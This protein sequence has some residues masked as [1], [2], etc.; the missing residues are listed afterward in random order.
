[1]ISDFVAGSDAPFTGY[2]IH[3]FK[4]DGTQLNILGVQNINSNRTIDVDF[5][6][7]DYVKIRVWLISNN[8][9][10]GIT[11]SFT[12]SELIVCEKD[13]YD[14]YEP[15]G[16]SP[17]P[18]YPS[19][20]KSV[21]YENLLN[22]IDG[23]NSSNGVV[24][25]VEKGI[26][27]MNGTYT[28]SDNMWFT[29]PSEEYSLKKGETYTYSLDNSEI[30]NNEIR[31][32]TLLS[33]YLDCNFSTINRTNTVTLIEDESSSRLQIRLIPGITFNNFIFKPKIEKGSIAH[34]YI[35]YGK[36]GIE[37]VNVGKNRLPN[38]PDKTSTNG[39]AVIKNKDG[40]ITLNGTSTA[41]SWVTIAEDLKLNANTYTL[42]LKNKM[43]GLGLYL[44]SD[45]ATIYA[46]TQ[47]QTNDYKTFTLSENTTFDVAR[48]RIISGTVFN[49]LT[50]YPMLEIGAMVTEY[51][52]CIS[53]STVFVLNEP[54]RS[55]PNG[56][57]DIAYLQNGKL[58]VERK[59]GR[60]IFDGSESGWGVHQ[61]STDTNFLY[62]IYQPNVNTKMPNCV[63]FVDGYAKDFVI[64]DKLKVVA[65][66]DNQTMVGT[67]SMY[68]NTSTNIMWLRINAKQSTLDEFKNWLSENNIEFTYE[69]ETPTTEEYD[70]IYTIPMHELET[71]IYYINDE[72]IPN[73]YCK[74]Y[75]I[76]AG[77]DGAPGQDGAPGKDA[78][79]PITI[80]EVKGKEIIVKD[81]K[82]A[83]NYI[84][85]GK[86][87]QKT[88]QGINQLMP[89]TYGETD[90]FNF[91]TNE[92]KS[93]T[94]Y[95]KAVP[96]EDN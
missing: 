41:N 56:A 18:E 47:T 74:Y 38:N 86:S 75:T 45:S 51:K 40:S 33:G 63:T 76:Y 68:S 5:N 29:I 7:Q 1:M 61:Y 58:H 73:V 94:E 31:T 71:D 65:A 9:A 84:I 3:G 6:T 28:G 2:E 13:L 35:P 87:E 81:G 37:V 72:L 82:Q 54:L 64:C 78:E 85:E 32:R 55:I 11:N 53:N 88:R 43:T 93:D 77:I 92:Y 30:L 12:I 20:I 49:N 70:S 34:P 89:F 46:V 52:P 21:G 57:K 44:G 24:A 39:V 10:T 19:E 8:T 83:I 69:L 23:V 15:Y 79:E 95:W 36:H 66:S 22:L 59:V 67:C 42:S 16:V 62:W 17:S 60:G 90:Y 27:T 4:A 91:I 96:I 50:I 48:I 80:K 25:T 26:V 14:G